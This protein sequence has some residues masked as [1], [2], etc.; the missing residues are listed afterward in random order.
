MTALHVSW[1]PI[2][3]SSVIVFLVSSLIHMVLPWHKSDCPK[4][5]GRLRSDGCGRTST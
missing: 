2:L 4:S 3:L 1:L 5:D